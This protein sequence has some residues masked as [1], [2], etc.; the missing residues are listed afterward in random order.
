MKKIKL[1]YLSVVSIVAVII[2]LLCAVMF[3]VGLSMMCYKI[4]KLRR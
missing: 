2:C 1:N 4:R 3:F